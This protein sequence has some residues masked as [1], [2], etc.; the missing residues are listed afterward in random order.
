[1][2]EKTVSV[3]ES[4]EKYKFIGGRYFTDTVLD[5]EVD[6]TCEPLG[7]HNKIVVAC[8]LL[9]GSFAAMTSR[10]SVGC[11]SPL[12][13]TIKES[14]VGGP[15]ARKM[16]LLE[17]KGIIIEDMPENDKGWYMLYVN[18]EGAKLMPA[19]E[20]VGLDNYDTCRLLR[21]KYG[22]VGVMTIGVAGE[23]QYFSATC[24]CADDDG[25]PARHAGRG[26]TGAVMGSK[27]IKCIV[28]DDKDAPELKYADKEAF[29]A[30]S[31]EWNKEIIPKRQLLTKLGTSN[32]VLT[33]SR[34]GNMGCRN[35]TLG[36]YEDAEMISGEHMRELILERGGN[37]SHGCYKGCIVRCSNVYNDAE[38]KHLTSSL[39]FETLILMGSNLC[40]NQIDEIAKLDRFCDGFGIDTMELGVSFAVA[41]ESGKYEFGDLSAVWEMVDEVKKDTVFGKVLA[42]GCVITGKV[43]G[44]QKVAAIK[45]QSFAAY[46]PRNLKGTAITYATSP[47]GADHTY[48]NCMPGRPGYRPETQD[49]PG[50]SDK[51]GNKPWAQD[52]QAL[53]AFCDAMGLC[54]IAVGASWDTASHTA[55][56]LEYEYGEPFTPEDM[57]AMGKKIVMMEVKWNERAGIPRNVNLIP[58]FWRE[59]PSPVNGSVFDVDNEE[60]QT[61]YEDKEFWGE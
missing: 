12:T 47:M 43:L 51:D 8:G 18:Y 58:E 6:L 49:Y 31:R 15:F 35:F 11:K 16:G 46:D 9:A 54:Y 19:D 61:F 4:P 33:T 23:R 45:G 37:P 40:I 20:Y 26:G 57:I 24:A 1:M 27:R 59:N 25:I 21:E 42:Q 30:H 55:K 7:R 22:N 3:E 13:G 50:V 53:T 5:E 41:M 10:T 14:N 28:M 48:G 29:V 2:R 52:M 56:L 36:S 39:E 38:G 34:L 44:V 60:V 32:L 17:Y